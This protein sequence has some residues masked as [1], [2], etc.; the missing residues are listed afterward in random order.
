LRKR[1]WTTLLDYARTKTDLHGKTSASQYQWVGIRVVAGLGLNYNVNQHSS[2]VEL[3]IDRSAKENKEIFDQ[4]QSERGHI[5]A[6][7]GAPLVW[8]RLD[9]KQASRVGF[10][11]EGGYRDDEMA[12]HKTHTAMVDAMIR[13][14]RAL[15]PHLT[16]FAAKT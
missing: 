11:I 1:F 13:F 16:R 6:D 4:L 5:E 8:E 14:E 10:L 9:D 7:F 15:R 3:Y 12:W 2:Y